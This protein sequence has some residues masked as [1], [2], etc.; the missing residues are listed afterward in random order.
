MNQSVKK[1]KNPLKK[2]LLGAFLI[3]LY[4]LLFPRSLKQGLELERGWRIPVVDIPELSVNSPLGGASPQYQVLGSALLVR[5]QDR[6]I[7]GRLEGLEY[8]ASSLGAFSYYDAS[9]EELVVHRNGATVLRLTGSFLSFW[10]GD[11]LFRQDPQ[12]LGLEELGAEG[13]VLWARRLASPLAV[14]DALD[15]L[16]FLGLQNGRI[17]ILDSQ[18]VVFQ[19]IQPGGSVYPSI[20]DLEL[21][22]AESRFSVLSGWEPLRYIVYENP[23]GEFRP[24]YHR[25]L[26][27][28]RNRSPMGFLGSDL[29]YVQDG[30][31]L[32]I[33]NLVSLEEWTFPLD[34]LVK[35]L[36]FDPEQGLLFLL[37]S[38]ENGSRFR[39]FNFQDYR[40]VDLFFPEVMDGFSPH[41]DSYGMWE[42]W[43]PEG[44][45]TLSLG[46]TEQES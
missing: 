17:L 2:I 15:D 22:S 34:G 24:I 21:E 13:T 38:N 36:F 23:A 37:Q 1:N 12:G 31:E 46:L 20:Y 6:E 18:G 10:H 27:S 39:V 16:S 40:P 35:G 44:L 29:S 8:L 45:F 9:R 32:A 33:V 43:G 42:F 5:G 11:R 3:L 41:G 4:V 25:T 7:Q 26:E 14:M 28:Q 19:E 30:P